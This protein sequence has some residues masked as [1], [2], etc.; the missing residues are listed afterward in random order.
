MCAILHS[1]RDCPR[2]HLCSINNKILRDNCNCNFIYPCR[3]STAFPTP[4]FTKLANVYQYFMQISFTYFRLNLKKSMK[5]TDTNSFIPLLIFFSL[6]Q[7]LR[8]SQLLN[9]ILGKS[10]LPN[11]ANRMNVQKT[12]EKIL[13]PSVRCDFHYTVFFQ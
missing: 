2:R 12:P 1:V 5:N 8:N 10:A 4:I 7:F 13:I 11:Y 9:K 3:K 6:P